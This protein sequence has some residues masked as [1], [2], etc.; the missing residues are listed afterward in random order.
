MDLNSILSV[1]FEAVNGTVVS[2]DNV[3][4]VLNATAEFN[5]VEHKTDI[6]Q[7]TAKFVQL[8]AQAAGISIDIVEAVASSQDITITENEPSPN[9]KRLSNEQAS[10]YA[11]MLNTARSKEAEAALIEDYYSHLAVKSYMTAGVSQVIDNGYAERED[12]EAEAIMAVTDKIINKHDALIKVV[13]DGYS[14][15]N[16]LI[17]IGRTAIQDVLSKSDNYMDHHGQ[18]IY[19][20]KAISQLEK[21]RN[22]NKKPEIEEIAT[23]CHLSA[24]RINELE[25]SGAVCISTES[26]D[27]LTKATDFNQ[28]ET[29]DKVKTSGIQESSID[30]QY[31]NSIIRHQL[32]DMIDSG[33]RYLDSVS[34]DI[35]Y[36]RT[37][38]DETFRSIASRTGLKPA[39]VQKLYKEALEKVGMTLEFRYNLTFNDAMAMAQ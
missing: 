9:H 30:Y 25:S 18:S 5:R 21:A 39:K 7:V 38:K 11:L 31:D 22:T 33:L 2:F 29:D 10:C 26:Y 35:F 8:Y 15:I 23:N 6:K 24:A 17:M 13:M 20:R 1:D 14:V 4:R 19:E 37:L 3:S 36:S 28:G 34:S 12:I 32:A 27:E 16:K